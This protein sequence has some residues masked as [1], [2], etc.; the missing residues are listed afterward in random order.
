MHFSFMG[1]LGGIT[2]ILVWA[3]TW[4][5]VKQFTSVKRMILGGIIGFVY[6]FLYSQRDFPN[7]IMSWVAGYMGTD[8]IEALIDRLMPK[9]A[10]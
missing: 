7:T 5:D 4:N 2:Y 1:L 6:F 8:F 10:G 3:K 9:E